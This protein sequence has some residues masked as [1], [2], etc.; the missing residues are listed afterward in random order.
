MD[1]SS[2]TSLFG[3]SGD[4]SAPASGGSFSDT[5]AALGQTALASAGSALGSQVAQVAQSYAQVYN[6]TTGTFQATSGNT[7]SGG[8]TAP[9]VVTPLSPAGL[10]AMLKA[11][12]ILALCGAAVAVLGLAWGVKKLVK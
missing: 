3:G 1:F 5:L 12:P 11:H 6:P 4:S 10:L 2:I 7:P 8:Q 9:A